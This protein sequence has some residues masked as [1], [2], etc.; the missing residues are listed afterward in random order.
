MTTHKTGK[1]T[2]EYV[3]LGMNL[4]PVTQGVIKTL[5]GTE[6]GRGLVAYSHT[7]AAAIIGRKS[8]EIADKLGYLGR[9]ELIHRDDMSL[10]K[11]SS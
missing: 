5:G 1:T 3:C 8:G 10:R 7:D 11:K 2:G 9:P 4:A 6:I